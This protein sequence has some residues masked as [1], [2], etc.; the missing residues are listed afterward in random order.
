MPKLNELAAVKSMT[1]ARMLRARPA[2]LRGGGL[3]CAR[4]PPSGTT[5]GLM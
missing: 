4:L 2:S 3:G 1:V 5:R